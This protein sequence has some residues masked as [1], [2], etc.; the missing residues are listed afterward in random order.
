MS[1]IASVNIGPIVSR[2]LAREQF[3]AALRLFIGRGKRYSVKQASNGSGVA[4]RMIEAFMANPESGDYRK[5][6][7]EEIISLSSF[8]G[9][10]FT[11]EWLKLAKQGAFALPDDDLPSPGELVADCANDTAEIADAGRYGCFDERDDS[12]LKSVG[13]REIDR[14]MKLVARVG[15]RARKA[16]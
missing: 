13:L 10:V 6:D 8:L 14:G 4:D 15:K 3:G 2:S 12:E 16:A 5:P 7:L 11:T 1:A 9:E